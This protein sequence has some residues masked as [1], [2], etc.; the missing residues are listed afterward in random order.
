[1]YI[2]QPITV[3][4]A[5][6]STAGLVST[7]TQTLAGAKTFSTSIAITPADA[8]TVNGV[9]VPQTIVVN[10]VL[11]ALSVSTSVFTADAAY[12]V[13]SMTAVWGVV[14][15]AGAVLGVEKLTGTTAPG[16]GTA[17][18]T[19]NL[20]L[21]ATA[22]TVTS[23]TLTGTIPSLQLASGNRLGVVLGGTLIGL[24]G[25]NVTVILKRI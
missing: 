5:S 6:A 23:G 16:S 14:G 3:P 13:V 1:M 9:I 18:L 8:L 11:G 19:G 7:G 20:D 24:V 12:Q 4:N 2:N 15:G 21:T 10:A 17:L 25:C 22:N